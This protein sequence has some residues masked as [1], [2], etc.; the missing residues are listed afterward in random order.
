MLY[1]RPYMKQDGGGGSPVSTVKWLLIILLGVFVLQNVDERLFGTFFLTDWLSFNGFQLI[2]RFLVWTP[3][4]YALLHAGLFHILGNGLVLFFLGRRVET[5]LGSGRLLSLFLL[6]VLTGAFT[7]LLFNF[8]DASPLI[9]ASAGAIGVLTVFCVLYANEPITLL[10][11][12]V[13]PITVKPKYLLMV[14][15]GM[16]IFGFL[17]FELTNSGSA[18]AH[19]AHLGGYLGGYLYYK[20][21]MERD[22]LFNK[23]P[24]KVTVEAP[25]WFKKRESKQRAK[26]TVNISDRSEL[27]GEVDRILDKINSKGFGSLSEEEK[28]ILDR[29][30]DILNR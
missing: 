7:W 11:F 27:K 5:A 8:G 13:L 18:I 19:S 12:F 26:T 3:L 15:L 30:K 2:E 17:F 4:T 16:D 6:T 29:A 10:L 23:T 20:Y 28:R 24:G 22:T 21:L 1:D 25:G 14:V 9:G